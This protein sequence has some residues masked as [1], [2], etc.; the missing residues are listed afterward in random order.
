MLGLADNG[1]RRVLTL[2][3]TLLA[4]IVSCSPT[5]GR[6]HIR[7]QRAFGCGKPV[8]LFSLPKGRAQV[9]PLGAFAQTIPSNLMFS[10]ILA[11]MG[12]I[13]STGLLKT[14]LKSSPLEANTNHGF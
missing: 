12:R 11:A 3:A 14:V 5:D 6:A 13:A 9:W 10:A 7:C 4:I 2:S 8:G 1:A